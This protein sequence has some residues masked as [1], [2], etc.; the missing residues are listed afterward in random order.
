MTK[1]QLIDEIITINP[2][3]QPGFLAGFRD[4]DLG[5]YLAHLN[6]VKAPLLTGDAARYR[7]YFAKSAPAAAINAD[8]A[9][10]AAPCEGVPGEAGQQ[11]DAL[12]TL[13]ASS[14]DDEVAQSCTPL[15]PQAAETP[16]VAIDVNVAAADVGATDFAATIAG[17]SSGNLPSSDD[18]ADVVWEDNQP[19]EADEAMERDPSLMADGQHDDNDGE[20]QDQLA[21]VAAKLDVEKDEAP[22]AGSDGE[23][24]S[25][26]F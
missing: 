25:Y 20:S 22:F 16:A 21:A 11:M 4:A 12:P 7:K 1:R 14:V 10:S 8:I 2:T 6:V 26:L 23:A 15:S 9:A 17:V 13:P 5:E 18:V 24:E 3:A 19:F